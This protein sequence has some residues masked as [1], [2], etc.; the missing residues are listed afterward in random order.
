MSDQEP[1]NPQNQ[2]SEQ[3][4]GYMS[5]PEA[6]AYERR[7]KAIGIGIFLVV[8]FGGAILFDMGADSWSPK[9][10]ESMFVPRGPS[11]G[12]DKPV[13]DQTAG[14][15]GGR[16]DALLLAQPRNAYDLPATD[17]SPEGWLRVTTGEVKAFAPRR[18]RMNDGSTRKNLYAR[19]E[20]FMPD[21]RAD[22]YFHQYM[23]L[24]PVYTIGQRVR[25]QYDPTA[26]DPCGT[27]RIVK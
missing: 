9:Q 20:Y 2:D 21:K 6:A 1:Q 23:G 24:E 15:A 4:G 27:S 13:P 19:T 22:C 18:D 25:I 10:R 26:D 16:A 12:A 11:S 7:A 5:A 3:D 17:K 14:A 8:L